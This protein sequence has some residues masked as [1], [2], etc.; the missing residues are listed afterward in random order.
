MFLLKPSI[1]MASFFLAEFSV[2]WLVILKN[3]ELAY[4]K[5]RV[6]LV[7][8]PNL[9]S[10][11]MQNFVPLMDSFDF[12]GFTSK[13]HNFDVREIPFEV[14]RLVSLGQ[15]ATP[16]V[17]R[18]AFYNI[19]GD[20]HDL[21]GLA[22]ALRGFDIVHTAE[23]Y[24]YCSYQAACAKRAHRFKLVVTVWENIPFLF[25]LPA[26]RHLKS[27]VLQEAD[28]FLAITERAREVLI[29]EGAP[30]EK[31]RAQMPGIDIQHFR[32]IPKDERLLGQFGCTVDDT[33]VLFVAH[34][35]VQ[36]GIYD[37]LCAF[38]R[39]LQRVKTTNIKLLIAGN[40][41]EEHTVR[42]FIAQFGL[43]NNV[44]LIGQYPYSRMPA[45]HNLADMFVLPS[46]PARE[47]Q[48]QFGYVLVESM[49]CGKPVIST[50]SGS[51]PEVVGDTGMLVPP[52]DFIALGNAIEHLVTADQLRDELGIK[53]RARAEQLF[54]AK[55]VALQMKDHY[56]ALLHE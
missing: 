34:L 9:N 43:Q 36:K 39:V 20:Y 12:V 16:R 56:E 51:I 45:I 37:L 24:Y 2:L 52:N 30:A 26:T 48:E 49:A 32:P 6:A 53:G 31:V 5:K 44:R 21:Q 4:V 40:G 54:D 41:P 17:L 28:L 27:I 7:R 14:R 18:K 19:L 8:G 10:W 47:W 25:N 55:K 1:W 29:L 13:G 33:V 3:S 15:L 11:E 23:S 38:K 35:Y 50:T 42:S 22:P 46:Q